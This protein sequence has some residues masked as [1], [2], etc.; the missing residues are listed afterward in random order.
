MRT[1]AMQYALAVA[2]REHLSEWL[3]DLLADTG[4]AEVVAR[5]VGNAGAQF[6]SRRCSASPPTTA[7]TRPCRIA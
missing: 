6:R 3:S 1:H 5:L 2:G 7:R 4:E